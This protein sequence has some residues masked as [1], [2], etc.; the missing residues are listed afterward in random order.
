MNRKLPSY[1]FSITT[2]QL[3]LSYTS[4]NTTEWFNLLIL[5][6][7]CIYSLWKNLETTYKEAKGTYITDFAR[8]LSIILI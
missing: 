2:I 8:T 6:Y 1:D 7:H 5:A 3:L 4:G